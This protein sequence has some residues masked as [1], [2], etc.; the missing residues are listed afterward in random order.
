MARPREFETDVAVGAAMDLFWRQGFEATSIHDLTR[1]LGIGKGSL[2]AAFTSKEELYAR[3][4][5]LYCSRHAGGLI[6]LLSA[7]TDVRSA[8]RGVLGSMATTD[9]D[10]PERG[11]ML[12][13]AA[14]ERPGDVAT[15]NRVRATM[16]LIE[17]VLA[18]ALERAQARGELAADK[19]PV[20]MARFL[21]TFVQGL[22]VMGG[23]RVGAAFVADAVEVALR[24]LD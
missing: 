3:A 22:R 10:D 2:Y 9:L 8:V 16:T 7:D 6:E 21:T 14:T 11:C 4:L 23:A 20:E 19:N 18:G 15:A 13:N 12:V 17:S 1:E 24:A 5:E